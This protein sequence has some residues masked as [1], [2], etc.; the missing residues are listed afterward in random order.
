MPVAVGAA[1]GQAGA[2]RLPG[3]RQADRGDGRVGRQPGQLGQ[4]AA[5][6]DG[7]GL[8]GVRRRDRHDHDRGGQQAAQR[9]NP[10]A[11]HPVHNSPG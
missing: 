8:G 11:Q 6:A 4:V 9:G 2:D 1:D 5:I 7:D 10:A 3:R